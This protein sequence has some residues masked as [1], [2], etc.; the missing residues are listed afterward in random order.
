M[1]N[2]RGEVIGTNTW[3]LIG[4]DEPQDWNVAVAHTALCDILVA[5]DESDKWD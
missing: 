3:T 1:V 5:C 2:S 4:D